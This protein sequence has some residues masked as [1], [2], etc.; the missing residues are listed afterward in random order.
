M[1]FV[2]HKDFISLFLSKKDSIN[3]S[4]NCYFEKVLFQSILEW[5]KGGGHKYNHFYLPIRM[6]GVSGST[7][8]VYPYGNKM[9]ALVKYVMYFFLKP[10]LFS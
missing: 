4:A 2:A 1:F 7:G 5:K 6:R 3:D 9:K 10:F 8:M